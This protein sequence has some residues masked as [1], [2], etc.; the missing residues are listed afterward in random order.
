[1]NEFLNMLINL[2]YKI[3]PLKEEQNPY[4]NDYLD[5]LI[6]QLKGALDTYPYLKT[7]TQY[8]SII[9]T[10]QYFYNNDF[11]VKQCKREVFKCIKTIKQIKG[12]V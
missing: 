12:G 7:N 9:N 4:L 3:L 1:M 5:S 2:V 6:I 10:V 11:T 8:I